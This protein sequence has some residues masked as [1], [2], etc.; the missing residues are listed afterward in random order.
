[1]SNHWRE[2]GAIL[3]GKYRVERILGEGAMGVVLAVR[4][5]VLGELVAMK[6]IRGDDAQQPDLL[7]RFRR[8]AQA[9][10]RIKSEHVVRT[11]DIGLLEDGTPFLVMEYLEGQDLARRLEQTGPLALWQVVDFTIQTCEA[12]AH[13]HTLGIVHR[14]LKPSNLFIVRCPDGRECVKVIDFGIAKQSGTGLTVAGM[15]LTKTAQIIG[16]PRYMAPEQ[17]SSAKDVDARSDIWSL[18]VILFELLSGHSPFTGKT[19]IS[20]YKDI[21]TS[22][23]PLLSRYRADLPDGIVAVVQRCMQKDRAYRYPSVVE[24]CAALRPF[25]SPQCLIVPEQLAQIMGPAA[26]RTTASVPPGRPSWQDSVPPTSGAG[27]TQHVF[28]RT[29]F[30]NTNKN[31]GGWLFVAFLFT[32]LVVIA[33]VYLLRGPQSGLVSQGLPVASSVSVSSMAPVTAASLVTTVPRSPVV[34]NVPLTVP[35]PTSAP[36][37]SQVQVVPV[38]AARGSTEVPETP[39]TNDVKP[40]S[41]LHRVDDMGY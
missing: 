20:L 12:L 26:Y 18:G 41:V 11:H 17:M 19:L 29:T 21:T 2:P 23:P 16:S 30:G 7:E 1:M 14:D 34:A 40:P 8:E 9:M 35:A 24:L 15:R 25:A 33:G 5:L 6:L 38:P 31:V 10:M 27:S 36:T 4:H 3:V 37:S 28:G 22:E 13:A 39:S 32:C